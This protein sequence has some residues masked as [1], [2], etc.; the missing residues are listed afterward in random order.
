M[1]DRTLFARC[2][3]AGHGH[4]IEGIEKALGVIQVMDNYF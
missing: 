2:N 4:Y 3:A 1:A